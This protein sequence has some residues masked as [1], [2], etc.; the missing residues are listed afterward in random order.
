LSRGALHNPPE[1]TSNP[2]NTGRTLGK[3]RL[4]ARL[5]QGGMAEVFLAVIAGP[6]DFSKLVVVKVMKSELLE[7]PDSRTMFLDEGRLAARLNHPNVVQTNEVGIEGESHFIAMEFLDGQPLHR[8]L[9]RA[10]KA[11]GIP[12]NWHLYF[13]AEV[14]HA[15][16][17]AHGVQDYDG[18]PLRMV[19]RDVTPH[20]VFVTYTGQVKLCDFGIA[21][22]MSSSVETQAGVLKGK[23]SYMAPEQVLSA[24]LDGRADLFSLGVMLWE[25]ATG[26]RMWKDQSD[27]QIMQALS[28]GRVPSARAANPTIDP[29]LEAVVNRALAPRPEDRYQSA[30]E[31]RHELEGFLFGRTARIKPKIM[32]EWVQSLFEK[33]RKNLQAVV[34]NQLAGAGSAPPALDPPRV[35]MS[36]SNPSRSVQ[37]PSAQAPSLTIPSVE[38]K[39]PAQ[40]RTLAAV[41]GA[42]LA[43]VAFLIIA[44]VVV[45]A[46]SRTVAP[47]PMVEAAP[48]SPETETTTPPAPVD[49]APQRVR[50]RVQVSPQSAKLT[51]DGAPLTDNPWV[52]EVPATSG[53][54]L[55]T[56]QAD[57][58]E[59]VSRTLKF[60]ENQNLE[61]QMRRAPTATAVAPKTAPTTEDPKKQEDFPDLTAQPK[62]KVPA[63]PLD[64]ADPW[65]Q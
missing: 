9:R 64:S 54:H 62:K 13:L 59:S 29:E 34:Q 16:E 5:G 61:I 18:T 11:D 1:G 27:L 63:A 23:V 10:K 2:T 33:E 19:H 43:V 47:T 24:Q 6:G 21:K 25:A 4:L 36:D 50:V 39:A 40:R 22:T 32:G 14:L 26:T 48:V 8:I 17:Y 7:E 49:T 46:R 56:A 60:D 28:H 53:N 42:L 52:G 35:A 45:V 58:Y 44:I 31:F 30:A 65:N 51:L 57:G 55:L 38:L 20:N 37:S 3:Y 12:L 41:V 15:L